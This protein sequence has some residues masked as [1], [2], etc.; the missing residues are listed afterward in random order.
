MSPHQQAF[1]LYPE[2]Y[3]LACAL[4][5]ETEQLKGLT[6]SDISKYIVVI[7][8][9]VSNDSDIL[10]NRLLHETEFNFLYENPLGG[11]IEDTLLDVDMK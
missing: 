8:T 10:I 11:K 7:N 5:G 3:P 9:T 1:R 4:L 2:N 6:D